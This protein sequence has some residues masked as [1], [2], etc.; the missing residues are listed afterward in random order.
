MWGQGRRGA[1]AGGRANLE[2]YLFIAPWLVGL[3]FLQL[4]PMIASFV[5]SFTHYEVLNP[6]VFIGAQNY[7][8]LLTNDP[9]FRKS[10]LNT[11]YYVGGSVP[12]RLLVALSL[13]VLLNMPFRGRA[14][15]RTLFYLPSVT[16]GVAVATVWLWMFEPTYG[17]IN[18]VLAWFRIP[19]PPWLGDLDWAMPSVILMSVVYIGQMMVVFL[20]GLQDVPQHLLEAAAIDGAGAWRR[21][22]HVTIPIL[23][24]TIFFNLV[25]AI[26]SSFQVFT[27]I[28]VMTRGGPANATYVYMLYLYDQAFRYVHMGY[29]CALAWVLFVIILVITLLQF[30]GSGW[31]Y[32]EGAR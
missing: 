10:L 3:V 23:S 20:A 25:M 22:L 7:V 19:G 21:F 6:A 28:Y 26:I 2:G 16:S 29:A 11:V 30:R 18:N 32:Y 9:L 14:L 12:I 13:A 27:S 5:L 15:F 31:V 17:V 1:G 4:G 8:D 24:P